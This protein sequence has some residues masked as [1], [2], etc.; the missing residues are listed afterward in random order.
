MIT[1]QELRVA[2]QFANAQ[3]AL[4]REEE[5]LARLQESVSLHR[6]MIHTL[7]KVRET[8]VEREGVENLTSEEAYALGVL[9][10]WSALKGKGTSR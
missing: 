2:R 9:D 1:Y 3:K 4:Q 6:S 10:R 5:A 8:I 7:R